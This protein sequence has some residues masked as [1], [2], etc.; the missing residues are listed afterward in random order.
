MLHRGLLLVLF[1]N[2]AFATPRILNPEISSNP[3]IIAGL[4][5]GPGQFPWQVSLKNS[6][7]A[8]FCGGSIIN[9]Q[10]ILTAAHC[11]INET[12]S[13]IGVYL[14][15]HLLTS[16]IRHDVQQIR[17]HPNFNTDTLAND[18]A[19]LR[20]SPNII[21]NDLTQAIPLVSR[22]VDNEVLEVSGWGRTYKS[23]PIPNNLQY[24]FTTAT[25]LTT[26]Q[27]QVAA[28]AD[29]VCSFSELMSDEQ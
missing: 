22:N 9:A 3:Y 4:Y 12:P 17:C 2:V 13:N 25:P 29:N 19:V 14:G 24:I 7:E 15:S 26:C 21:F 6:T 11:V 10:Y 28:N 23:G 5:A 18:I 16:Q 1:V 20:V 27:A 8:H